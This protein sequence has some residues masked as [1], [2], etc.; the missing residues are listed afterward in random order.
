MT[1][2]T[3]EFGVAFHCHHDL[4]FEIVEGYSERVAYIESDKP[5]NEQPLRL[6]LFQMIPDEQL[7]LAVADLV[8]PARAAWA[9]LKPLDDAYWA[10]LKALYDAYSA[11]RKPLDDAYWAKRKP[12]DEDYEAK[13]KPLN[14][15]LVSHEAELEALHTTLCHDCPWD[16]KTIFPQE[17]K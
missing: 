15:A 1:T 4:L 12:L 2:A 5:I 8:A 13:L 10:K 14:D 9:K 7:P 6:R 11:K 16:G 3:Q 17:E